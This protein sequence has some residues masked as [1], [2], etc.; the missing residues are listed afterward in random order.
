MT[1]NHF[2]KPR[3]PLWGALG[4]YGSVYVGWLP[5]R[6]AGRT[7]ALSLKTLSKDRCDLKIAAPTVEPLSLRICLN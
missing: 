3:A 6:F 2:I 4:S 7:D 1:K 5:E